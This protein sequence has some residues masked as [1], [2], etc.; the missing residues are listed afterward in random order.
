MSDPAIG[1]L[2]FLI[3]SD[4]DMSLRRCREEVREA[5]EARAAG[6]NRSTKTDAAG[7]SEGPIPAAVPARCHGEQ[8][9]T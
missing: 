8:E 7:R 2:N 4:L 9:N 5:R 6:R 3:D 1:F